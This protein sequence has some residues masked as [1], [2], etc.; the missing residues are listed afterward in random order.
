MGE[1]RLSYWRWGLYTASLADSIFIP[2]VGGVVQVSKTGEWVVVLTGLYVLWAMIIGVFVLT[3]FERSPRFIRQCLY[4]SF[5]TMLPLALFGYLVDDDGFHF[6]LPF[7]LTLGIFLGIAVREC[8]ALVTWVR[9]RKSLLKA[10]GAPAP[11]LPQYQDPLPPLVPDSTKLFGTMP[12]RTPT[13]PTTTPCEPVF[14]S[15]VRTTTPQHDDPA[16]GS[17]TGPFPNHS[18]S[19]DLYVD[20]TNPFQNPWTMESRNAIMT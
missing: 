15:Q 13:A 20:P 1:Q 3:F 6:W 9:I 19:P 4:Y 17:T 11:L 16:S 12:L 5:W 14:A 8:C 10:L 7:C 18:L 2:V